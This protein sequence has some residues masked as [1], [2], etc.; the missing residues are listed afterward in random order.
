MVDPECYLH[1]HLYLVSCPAPIM[2]AR[3]K[4]GLVKRV[5]L[6]CP[7]GPIRLQNCGH[8]T[9]VECHVCSAYAHSTELAVSFYFLHTRIAN[10]CIP[11]R[12]VK[13]DPFDQTLSL[14]LCRKGWHARLIYT[15]HCCDG[16][17]GCS[18]SILN[19]RTYR[20]YTNRTQVKK[21]N[22]YDFNFCTIFW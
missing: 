5:A 6:P 1:V 14:F 19:I 21:F 22:H 4:K 11:A 20:V 10:Y 17:S 18:C 13:C 16:V 2:H 8:M 15:L 9:L 3:E 12:R 7:C